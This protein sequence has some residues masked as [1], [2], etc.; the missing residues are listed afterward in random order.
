[1][2]YIN[3]IILFLIT[4]ILCSCQPSPSSPPIVNKG[5]DKLMQI[6]NAT[7]TPISTDNVNR[8]TSNPTAGVTYDETNYTAPKTYTASLSS[9]NDMIQLTIDATVSIPSVHQ[10]PVIRV[11]PDDLTQEQADRYISVL[12]KGKTLYVPRTEREWSKDEIRKKILELKLGKNSDLAESDPKE[13]QKFIAPELKLLEELLANAPEKSQR[14][15]SDGKFTSPI[16]PTINP[17]STNEEKELMKQRFELMKN[18]KCIFVQ[19][20]MNNRDIADLGII[21]RNKLNISMYFFTSSQKPGG[22]VYPIT[23]DTNRISTSPER[24]QVLANALMNE[25]N[26]QNFTVSAYGSLPNG[27]NFEKAESYSDLPKCYVFYYTRNINGI[28]ATYVNENYSIDT[29]SETDKTDVYREYWPSEVVTIYVDNEGII[30]LTYSSPTKIV[31]TLNENV[32]LLPFDEIINRFKQQII[33]GGSWRIREHIISRRLLIDRIE[34]GMARISIRD[35]P[36]EYMYVPVWDFFGS[37]IEKYD[38][39]VVDSNYNENNEY[40]EKTFGHSYLTINAIDGSIIDR[41]L[42]Y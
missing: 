26:L 25:M 8:A 22:A 18:T 23:E 35:K 17:N 42:G 1:M 7:N 41:N 13:Y 14:L 31:D 38:K 39:T 19:A 28:T 21:K 16:M 15:V 10:Y 32:S 36:D 6:I 5:D 40:I 11:V 37:C 9:V 33:I 29:K 27:K 2:K 3:I 20:D 30:G 34:L 12:L 24:A 4:L